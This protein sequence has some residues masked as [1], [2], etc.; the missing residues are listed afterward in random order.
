MS[1]NFQ[2][3][4]S[5]LV[6]TSFLKYFPV[7]ELSTVKVCLTTNVAALSTVPVPVW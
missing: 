4:I 3:L 6:F 7:G 5:V 1:F 2:K